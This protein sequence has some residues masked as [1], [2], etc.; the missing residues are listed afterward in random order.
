MQGYDIT[1]HVAKLRQVCVVHGDCSSLEIGQH[2]PWDGANLLIMDLFDESEYI[3][4]KDQARTKEVPSCTYGHPNCHV[5]EVKDP[6]ILITLQLFWAEVF[7]AC[8]ELQ[9]GG[10]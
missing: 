2:V 3:G 9:H 1:I 7:C 5:M 4:Q 10:A 8:C 6:V